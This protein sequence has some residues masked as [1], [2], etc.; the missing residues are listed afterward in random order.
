M[1]AKLFLYSFIS[2]MLF[3]GVLYNFYLL[4]KEVVFE[5][6]GRRDEE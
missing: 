3:S 6:K 1:E 2:G 4:V 5:F